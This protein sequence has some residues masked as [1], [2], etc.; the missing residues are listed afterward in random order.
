MLAP[1][2][3]FVVT[4]TTI[5]AMQVFEQIFILI[6]PPEGPGNSTISLVLYLYRSGFQNFNQGYA[7][8]IAW[9]LFI[10]IFG[11]TLLQFQRQR[12]SSIYEG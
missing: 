9:V 6:N 4:M 1:T 10:L 5:Q 3:F 7:S 8:A 11:L 2:T 12:K